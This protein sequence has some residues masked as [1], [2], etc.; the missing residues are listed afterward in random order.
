MAKKKKVLVIDDEGDLIDI[1]KMRLE[2]AGFEVESALD[3]PLGIEKTTNF[4]PDFILL[5]VSM[6]GMDGWDVCEQLKIN[7]VTKDIKIIILT[8]TR[9]LKR[10][11][12]VQADRVILKPFNY[13]EILD[14]LK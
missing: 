11:K 7:P 9:N 12:D 5:D 6:P 1:I 4:K 10:A 14:V 13:E 3:G 8:A 2:K